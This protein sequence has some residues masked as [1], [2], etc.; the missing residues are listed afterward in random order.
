MNLKQAAQRLGVHYQTAYRW[1]RGG[2]LFAVKVGNRYEVSEAS[3][4][5]FLNRRADLV[6]EPAF[7][8]TPEPATTVGR[9]SDSADHLAELRILAAQTRA[10]AQRCFDQA[11]VL[12]GSRWGDAA[13]L[14]LLDG[15]GELLQAV[16]SY[17]DAPDDRA[18]IVGAIA[19]AGPFPR[20]SPP[21]SEAEASGGV[22]VV[23]HMPRDLI[24][25]LFGEEGRFAGRGVDVLAAAVAPMFVDRDFVGGLLAVKTRSRSPFQEG[26]IEML[27][28]VASLCGDAHRRA[29][30]FR[31]TWRSNTAW[32]S[33]WRP[34]SALTP[35]VTVT[36]TG[37]SM[38][39]GPRPWCRRAEPSRPPPTA[40]EPFIRTRP[41]PGS[42]A[43]GTRTAWPTW[44]VGS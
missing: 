37:G 29:E 10:T 27:Q 43:V 16:S 4:E 31:R 5:Q 34:T 23:H 3:I 20:A 30:A 24:R 2:E 44:S 25:G 7:E 14:R 12:A 17:A 28:E 11:T 39:T 18:A 36:S 21:W 13:V 32:W 6:A 1:V 33:G 8:P 35:Q 41:A 40:S 15:E 22:H 42:W 38:P 26:E 9:A 19:V